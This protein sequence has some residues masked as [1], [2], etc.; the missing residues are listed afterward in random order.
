MLLLMHTVNSKTTT[1][2]LFPSATQFLAELGINTEHPVIKVELNDNPFDRELRL[3]V[4]TQVEGK[5][6]EKIM[7]SM[8]RIHHELGIGDSE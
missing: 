4:T 3:A 2:Y 6:P 8:D 1:T 5:V 7:E